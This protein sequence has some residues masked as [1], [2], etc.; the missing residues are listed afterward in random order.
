MAYVKGTSFQPGE[1]NK[2]SMKMSGEVNKILGFHSDME[3]KIYGEKK[4]H[5][6]LATNMYIPSGGLDYIYVYCDIIHPSPFG[7]QIV[8]ILD[9]FTFQNGFNKGIHNAIYKSVRNKFIDEIAIIVTDQEGRGI[10]F[11]EGTSITC[12]LHI[13]P[14]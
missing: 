10:H 1:V 2:I 3:Y 5:E 8:N 4:Q 13:R 11:C 14:H 6:I 9:C 7:N 12:V